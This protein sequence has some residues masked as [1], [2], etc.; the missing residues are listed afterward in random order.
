MRTLTTVVVLIFA[1]AG[2]QSGCDESSTTETK[3]TVRSGA[4][5][6]GEA[7]EKGAEKTG[8][9]LNKAA[10]STG[11]TIEKVVDAASRVDVDVKVATKPAATRPASTQPSPP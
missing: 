7:L 3:E 10:K 1:F 11:E 4:E 5:K 8:E 2:A 9:A 6:T